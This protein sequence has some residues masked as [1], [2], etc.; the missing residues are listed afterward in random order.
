MTFLAHELSPLPIVYPVRV[1]AGYRD[2]GLEH[3]PDRFWLEALAESAVA[4]PVD[5]GQGGI[6][7]LQAL[8]HFQRS[9]SALDKAS[10]L[11]AGDAIEQQRRA[12]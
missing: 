4:T 5:L 8:Y 3:V 7:F 9:A 2:R 1:H 6:P 12:P 11:V 10:L